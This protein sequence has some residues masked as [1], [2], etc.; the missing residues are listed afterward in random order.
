[1]ERSKAV[2]NW[3]I[4][5]LGQKFPVLEFLSKVLIWKFL[6]CGAVLIYMT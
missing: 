1:S 6:L 3:K 5:L 4:S 2:R